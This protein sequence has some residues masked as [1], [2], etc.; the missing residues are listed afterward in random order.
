MVTRLMVLAVLAI[1]AKAKADPA[2][3]FPNFSDR[4]QIT[5]ENP[6]D[7]SYDGV[8]V[9]KLS[10]LK[11]L[12]SMF[13][14]TLLLAVEDQGPTHWLAT[15]M[16]SA[17]GELA[18]EV[19]LDPHQKKSIS[20]YYSNAL[21]DQ[22]PAVTRVYASH[23]Y[24]YNHATATIES[25]LAGYRT[26]GGFFL[27][28]Q[29]HAK[30]ERGLFNE[31][32]GYSSISHPPSEGEDVIHL[33]DTLG[34]GGIFLRASDIVYRPPVSTPDYAHR[35]A[36]AGEPEYEVIAA[37]PLRAIIEER[38]RDWLIGADHV[39]LRARYEMDAGQEVVHCHWWLTPLSTTRTY[40]VGAGIRDLPG[41]HVAK[42]ANVLVTE[43]IQEAS[44]GPVALG[45]SFGEGA[46]KAGPLRTPGGDNE[47][48][49]F[50]RQLTP[51]GPVE[52][53]YTVAAAWQG[54]GRN[55]PAAHLTDVLHSQSRTVRT[56]LGMHTTNP[57]PR[58]LEAE[59]K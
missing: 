48:V 59:P 53:E 13:P 46:S 56:Q 1:A 50:Q 54:S 27:D 25:E 40:E 36:K 8:A 49:V 44:V 11:Q 37:G 16:D 45:L 10:E 52:G 9:M 28:V 33:G 55:D 22:F 29:A 20:I 3:E 24:G 42:V 12:D 35:A 58:A 39:S 17:E 21:H 38:L 43:G 31:M 15:Q 34:L 51:S 57:N 2:W 19:H 4:I 30:G 41:G 7:A 26:Y 32:L 6:Q 23:N 5:V 14:G 18:L 47:V